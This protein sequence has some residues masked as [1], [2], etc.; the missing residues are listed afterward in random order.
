MKEDEVD[1]TCDTHGKRE[2][3]IQALE[4]KPKERNISEDLGIDGKTTLKLILKK[5]EWRRW[6]EFFSVGIN[7]SVRAL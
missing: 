6:C 1:G 4:V 7:T 3:R 5:E 2:E